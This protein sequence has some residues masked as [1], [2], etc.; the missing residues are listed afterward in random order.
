MNPAFCV[1]TLVI[2]C[3]LLSGSLTAH[4]WPQA[5]SV[6]SPLPGNGLYRLL[7]PPAYC[8]L[9]RGW[10]SGIPRLNRPSRDSDT[11]GVWECQFRGLR[12]PWNYKLRQQK[13]QELCLCFQ[14][15][16]GDFST[17]SSPNVR[18]QWIFLEVAWGWW[19][20]ELLL[21]VKS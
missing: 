6:A 12:P 20:G 11:G 13:Q 21:I 5:N 14:M 2:K 1:A 10:S 16:S 4:R 8:D 15:F 19:R 7:G 18:V 17:P 3:L 9:G